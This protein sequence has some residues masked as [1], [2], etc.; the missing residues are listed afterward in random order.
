[1]MKE[2]NTS[3]AKTNE[4]TIKINKTRRKYP[5]CKNRQRK[6]KKFPWQVRG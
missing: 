5:A 3:S 2:K 1:M 6:K 4:K